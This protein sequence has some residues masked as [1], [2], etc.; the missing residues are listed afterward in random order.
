M[1][2]QTVYPYGTGG[3]L[4]SSIGIIN[5]LTTGGADKALAAEQGKVLGDATTYREETVIDVA[6]LEEKS[7]YPAETVWTIVQNK[8]CTHISVSVTEGQRVKIRNND[9][10]GSRLFLLKQDDVVTENLQVPSFADGV[11]ERI[12]CESGED[13]IIDIPATCNYLIISKSYSVADDSLPVSVSIFSAE[14]VAL[15]DKVRE[16]D[17]KTTAL[18]GTYKTI[19]LSQAISRSG[20]ID[21]QGKWSSGSHKLI[22][23][24]PGM[25]YYVKGSQYI[26][27]LKNNNAVVS[28]ETAPVSDYAKYQVLLE[29]EKDN[30]VV[31]PPDAFYMLFKNIS[32]LLQG[33]AYVEKSVDTITE[34]VAYIVNRSAACMFNEYV[35]GWTA[36][37][38]KL[39]DFLQI[40]T[41]AAI[42]K[43]FAQLAASRKFDE[44]LAYNTPYACKVQA[45]RLCM[46]PV[47]CHVAVNVTGNTW[48]GAWNCGIVAAWLAVPASI[49]PELF[50][51]TEMQRVKTMLAYEADRILNITSDSDLYWSTNPNSY[52]GDSRA[53][54]TAW[55]AECLAMAV[56]LL[57]GYNNHDAYKRK[58][59]ELSIIANSMPQDKNKDV[60]INGYNLTNL[61]G[62]NYLDNGVLYNHNVIHPDYMMSWIILSVTAYMIKG[63]DVPISINHNIKGIL[64]SFTDVEYVGGSSIKGTT[65]RYPGGTIFKE[66][67][68]LVYYPM[69]ND[70]A[71]TPRL[72]RAF[73]LGCVRGFVGAVDKD[74]DWSRYAS[75][76]AD[77]TIGMKKRF[78]N[79]STYLSGDECDFRVTQGTATMQL[80]EGVLFEQTSSALICLTYP[81]IFTEDAWYKYTVNGT[82]SGVSSGTIKFTQLFGD[83]VSYEAT[84]TEGSFSI[85][86]GGGHYGISITGH[87]LDTTSVNVTADATLAIVA[88]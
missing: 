11:T 30:T 45:H 22:A 33:D 61:H 42:A 79:G 25:N 38:T 84:I 83:E 32:S 47:N 41:Y 44:G 69:G 66:S 62:Y 15:K 39:T 28:G 70:W 75:M 78:L 16:L 19:D 40:H 57:E 18:E 35:R 23:C 59:I 54:D 87:T 71:K 68:P 88:S 27:W 60:N 9:T 81:Y 65:I 53:D 26:I 50:S 7:G 13:T 24:E 3:S 31:S 6:S 77:F 67:H 14:T 36:I 74:V 80:P 55:N 4:P 85:E 20:D 12:V 10:L 86:L 73:I 37:E 29:T 46:R 51:E 8:I 52:D 21:I 76:F 63:K 56:D 58:L 72:F 5:D 43:G 2:N 17:N 64:H 48:G 1:A 49:Y 82:V 34:K